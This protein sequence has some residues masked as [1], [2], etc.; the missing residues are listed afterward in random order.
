[1]KK[2]LCQM[3]GLVNLDKF[4]TYPHC[5]GCGIRL[6]ETTT[7]SSLE[8]WK[9]PLGT[10]LWATI[11]G[12]CCAGLAY[13]GI[14]IARETGHAD[15]SKLIAYIEV[16]RNASVGTVT[17]VKLLPD[18]V[19]S[20]NM[21]VRTFHDVRL[22]VSRSNFED[23]AFVDISPPSVMQSEGSGRYFVYESLAHDEPITLKLRPL[24]AG[25]AQLSLSLFARDFTPFSIRS[26]V[27]VTRP[28]G[29][30]VTH[31]R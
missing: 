5:A 21:P 23:F 24:R 8:N 1:M 16:P 12:L 18:S 31:S 17:F 10:P 4:V 9:R 15:A 22:R 25:Q 28:P 26:T 20:E 13:W 14:T 2:V 30:K 6:A 7:P 29:L 3:C 19:E 11:I 27:K